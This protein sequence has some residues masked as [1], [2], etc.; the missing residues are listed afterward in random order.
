MAVI[1][2]RVYDR[3]LAGLKRFQPIL[4]AAKSRDA[5][6]ADTSTIVKDMLSEVFGYDKYT[7]I[8]SEFMIK[9]TYCDLAVKLDGKL[10]LLVEVKA[11]GLDL[12]DAH[13]KQAVDYAANQG[14][15]WVI[16][17][18][19][20]VW[21]VYRVFFGQ[22]ISQEMIFE[23]DL[24]SLNPKNRAQAESLFLLA[25]EGQSKSVLHD[26]HARM[27][28]MSRHCLGALILDDVV[29]DVIRRE[30]RRLSPDIRIDRE[31]LRSVLELEVLKR[32]VTEGEK[33]EEA[34]RKIAKSQARALRVR[35]KPEEEGTPARADAAVASEG[36]PADS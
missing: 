6:E 22:P 8:T 21:R 35:S 19:G 14:V 36:H 2:S 29:L 32:E 25:R 18:N 34:R 23:C 9:G 13:T 5:G 15:E 10:R 3:L 28:A 33:A 20:A 26:Y 24:L 16:L 31:E 27:Q 4:S 12:K 7:E 30:L 17:T 1:P 11:I